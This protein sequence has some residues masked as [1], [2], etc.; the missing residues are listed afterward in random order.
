MNELTAATVATERRV[1]CPMCEASHLT[2]R[3]CKSVCERCGYVESCEDNF[4]PNQANP[5]AL[6][7]A[8]AWLEI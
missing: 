4:V 7:Q 1:L 8:G 3:H 2:A 6:D 5:S